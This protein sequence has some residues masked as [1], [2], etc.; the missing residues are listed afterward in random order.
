MRIARTGEGDWRAAVADYMALYVP[1]TLASL[2]GDRTSD[3]AV[4]TDALGLPV[5]AQA[6]EI[7]GIAFKRAQL[8]RFEGR[9]LAQIAYLDP[10]TGPMAFCFTRMRTDEAPLRTERRRDMN[11]AYWSSHEHAFLVVG[12]RS[13]E[14]LTGIATRLRARFTV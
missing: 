5:S 1:E 3:L 8:L 10:V 9:P 4:L 13:A 12:R 14:D 2:A 7:P 6:I 11:L